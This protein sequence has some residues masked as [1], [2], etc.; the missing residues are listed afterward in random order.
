MH[1]FTADVAIALKNYM[2][3]GQVSCIRSVDGDREAILLTFGL[4]DLEGQAFLI[5]WERLDVPQ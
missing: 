4:G 3:D 2:A 5:R 1:V